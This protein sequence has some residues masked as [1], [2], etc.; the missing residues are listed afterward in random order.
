MY[1]PLFKMSF[2]DKGGNYYIATENNDASWTVST[3]STISYLQSLPDGWDNTSVTWTRDPL[4][5]GVFRSM[6]SNGAY[7]FGVDGRAI[8]QSVRSAQ[9][10]QGYILF[11]I[12]MWNEATFSYETFYQSELDFKTY[13]DYFQ[14]ELLA[15][16]TLDNGLIRQIHAYGNTKFNVPIWTNIGTDVDPIWITDAKFVLHDGI[17]LLYNAT[18]TSSANDS[19]GTELNYQTA[20][21]IGGFNHGKHNDSGPDTGMHTIP[22]MVQYNI[23]QN[24]GTT[25]YIGNTILATQLIQGNQRNSAGASLSGET[26]FT[27]A[28]DSQPYTTDNYCLKNLLRTLP[29]NVD[30]WVSITAQIKDGLYYYATDSSETHYHMDF[31]LF[32][33]DSTNNPTLDG[34]GRYVPHAVL[35]R[36]DLPN[37]YPGGAPYAVPN[38]G[39][40]PSGVA[41]GYINT[42]SNPV[43][44]TIN[45]NKAYV[46]CMI[47]D[48]DLGLNASH[49]SGCIFTQLQFSIFSK[50]TSGAVDPDTGLTYVP[51]PKLNPSVFPALRP[52]Q[53]LEKIVPMLNTTTTDGYGFPLLNDSPYSGH[54]DYLSDLAAALVGDARPYQCMLTSA[55]CIHDLQGQSYI[56]LS[57]NDLTDYLK[58][59]W[60]CAAAIEGDVFRVEKFSYFFDKDTMILDLGYDI[61]EMEDMELTDG[62]GANLKL[63]YTK[64]DTN[65]NFGVE[66]VHTE[67]YY[68][69]PLSNLP[70]TMDYEETAVL[71][72]PYAIELL[73]VQK[74]S[75]PIG[76]SYDPANPSGDNQLVALYVLPETTV[77]LP[78]A[79]EG[80]NHNFTPYDPSNNPVP[81]QAYQLTQRNGVSLPAAQSTTQIANNYIY[82]MYYPDTAVNMELT[83]GRNIN[84]VGGLIHSYMDNLEDEKLTFRNTSVMQYNNVALGLS[85]IESNL[86]S[87]AVITEFKDKNIS[88]LP[89]KLFLPHP[90]KVKSK[91]PVNMY[92][93]LTSNANGYVRWF[94]KGKGFETKEY[95]A[96]VSKAIQSAGNASPTDFIMWPTPDEYGVGKVV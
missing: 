31:V 1:D 28:N 18:F 77:I 17:K 37:N 65:S 76:V 71:C 16:S 52:Y 82:G 84:R 36:L 43:S 68:N 40:A 34:S 62:L 94:W 50:Y 67:L 38:V 53:L 20:L 42:S 56:T 60:G 41:S 14:D 27:R 64:E 51:A 21:D 6:S 83:P 9:G 4:Y 92:Q 66:A 63:G 25:T 13:H 54:S 11:T 72:E 89:Q 26:N 47:F 10:I 87:G 91:Y 35:Y 78:D 39:L 22:N 3:E 96:F 8:I 32:E 45:P 69:T 2:Q 44:V 75:Q 61:S 70:A 30:V 74:V 12:Y 23:I 24:N 59:A 57:L 48:D 33:I 29:G 85:G 79:T 88:D 73:R 15:I 58:K 81:C 95:H 49:T 93:I 86:D 80:S 46:L 5:L 19:E 90:K 7:K 55:Y